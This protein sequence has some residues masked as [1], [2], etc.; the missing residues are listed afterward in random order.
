MFALPR[1]GPADIPNLSRGPP[2]GDVTARRPGLPDSPVHPPSLPTPP[3]T[4]FPLA[5]RFTR[6]GARSDSYQQNLKEIHPAGSMP[7]G[8]SVGE[9]PLISRRPSAS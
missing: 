8:E 6:V 3:P 5:T 9:A 1:P 7:A 4:S 2:V